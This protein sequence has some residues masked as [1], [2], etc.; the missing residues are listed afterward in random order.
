MFWVGSLN[1]DF[2]AGSPAKQDQEV[3]IPF[4]ANILEIILEFRA[5]LLWGAG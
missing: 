2:S 5:L 1:L 3:S 4:D